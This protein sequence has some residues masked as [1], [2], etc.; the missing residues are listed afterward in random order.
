MVDARKSGA[1]VTADRFG[2][3]SIQT[4]LSVPFVKMSARYVEARQKKREACF[5]FGTLEGQAGTYDCVIRDISVNGVRVVLPGDTSIGAHILLTCPETGKR[6]ACKVVWQ[7]GR[8]AG[9]K[10]ID[11][12]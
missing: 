7:A 11:R 8:E 9:L 6:H 3:V 2:A 12:S 10:I 4:R 1:R 5:R